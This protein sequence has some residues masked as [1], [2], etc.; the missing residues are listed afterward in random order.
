MVKIQ[1]VFKARF[2]RWIHR[3]ATEAFVGKDVLSH[4]KS[5]MHSDDIYNYYKA[6]LHI[7]LDNYFVKVIRQRCGE[8][9]SRTK[10]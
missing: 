5:F 6:L 8:C 7:G 4:F 10:K 2:G 1:K 9:M 3:Q